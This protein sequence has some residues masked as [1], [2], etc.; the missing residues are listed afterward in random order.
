V[1]ELRTLV[2]EQ[3]LRER[4]W[5]QL[6]RALCRG[7][8][9]AE[10]L[11]VYRE[12]RAT[13][14]AELG[15]EPGPELHGLEQRVL[16]QDPDLAATGRDPPGH[17]GRTILVLPGTDEAVAPLAGL[18]L[19]IGGEPIVRSPG[20]ARGA[21]RGER[22][23]GGVARGRAGGPGRRLHLVHR[24]RD[25]LRLARDENVALL[26]CDLPDMARLPAVLAELLARAVCDVA[27][28]AGPQR[29]R[30]SGAP[31]LVPFS[32]GRHDWAAAE[33]AAALARTAG[34]S[35]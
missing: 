18:A 27:L 22:R 9:Q 29:P 35:L 32:G 26:I 20:R 33:L 10:A 21:E 5:A 31:I 30:E 25:A 19:S 1:G 3:P 8:R 7:G 12:A 13:L 28:V 34:S 15:L 24:A 11:A 4:L 23:G 2:A 16:A 14:V 17:R 6:M